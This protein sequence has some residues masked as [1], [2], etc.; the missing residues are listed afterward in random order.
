M[1]GVRWVLFDDWMLIGGL[2]GDPLAVAA[3]LQ[4]TNVLHHADLAV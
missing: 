3:Y 1:R 4:G 2:Y